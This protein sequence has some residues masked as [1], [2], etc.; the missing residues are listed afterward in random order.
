MRQSEATSWNPVLKG[1]ASDSK[2]KF[3]MNRTL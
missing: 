2:G 3:H 1:N